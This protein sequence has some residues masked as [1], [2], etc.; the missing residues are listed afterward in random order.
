MP[1][2][3][4]PAV[5]PLSKRLPKGSEGGKE[6]ARVIDLLL[7][8]H[9]RREHQTLTHVDDSAGDYLALDSFAD[10]DDSGR[11]GYQYKFYASPLSDLH[12]ASIK[13]A[14]RHAVAKLEASRIRRLVII[15]PD[16]LL[17]SAA[18]RG[19]GD[20]SWF[21]SMRALFQDRIDVEH[22]GHRRIVD[23]FLKSPSICL[24]YYPELLPDGNDRRKSIRWTRSRYD[25]NLRAVSGNVRFVGMSVHTEEAS[26][27]VKLE[28]IYIPLRLV[29]PTANP[30]EKDAQLQNPVTLLERNGRHVIL[31]D[32]GSGKSTLLKCLAIV[33]QIAGLQKRVGG[34]QDTERIPVLVSL[35]RYADE[36]NARP[37]LPLV[38]YLV[39]VTRGDFNLPSADASF[40]EFYLETGRAILC[41]DGFDELPNP[42]IKLTV[43]D[44]INS[45]LINYPGNTCIVSSRIVGYDPYRFG[46]DFQHR[47]IAPLRL[48]EIEQFI[49][50]WYTLREPNSRDRESSTRDLIK[51]IKDPEHRDILGLATNPLLLT[52]IALVHR[53]DSA[54]PAARADLYE[55]CT[56][57]LLNKWHMWKQRDATDHVTRGLAER[58]N[59]VRIEVIA[60]WMQA[61][62]VGTGT[63]PRALAPEGELR[64]L[65]TQ[66]IATQENLPPGKTAEEEAER[67]LEFV[68]ERAGLLVEAGERHYSFIHLTFQEYLTASRIIRKS[69]VGGAESLWGMIKHRIGDGRW[70]DTLRLLI[71]SEDSG[72]MRTNLIDRVRAAAAERNS[73][74]RSQLLLGLLIDR[75][76]E[77]ERDERRDSAAGAST[78][79]RGHQQN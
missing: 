2:R 31:G 10:C 75:I 77:A 37:N 50:D 56:E 36:L 6:F 30:L 18:R 61:Q 22:W 4:L 53:L 26:R 14:V 3:R 57:T 58:R 28:Q 62:R 7:I 76:E 34:E 35:R 16:D 39:E 38:S 74:E 19:G 70:E 20:V 40:F 46:D 69:R 23:M 68:R 49:A 48:P 33:G 60:E 5:P 79:K 55:S 63:T 72:E 12:R 78:V 67:F 32:P 25:E 13:R 44:R 9:A 8:Q 71:A 64:E 73:V 45:L 17:E 15:T 54:L 65:L 11:S 24:I 51:V 66:H 59:R 21:Q 47:K 42:Q 27:V 52:I 41:F 1:A 29:A 43:R